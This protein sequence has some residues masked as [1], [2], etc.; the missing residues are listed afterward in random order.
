M[1][2][3]QPLVVGEG[4]DMQFNPAT[5]KTWNEDACEA[6]DWKHGRVSK[7][8]RDNYDAINWNA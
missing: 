4:A 1:D 8:Y 2:K 3:Q 7:A 5:W 6:D